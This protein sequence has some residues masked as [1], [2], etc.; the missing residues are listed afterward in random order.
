MNSKKT[1]LFGGTFNPPH[2]GHLLIARNIKKEFNL[3]KIIFIPA[4]IPP[5]KQS[6]NNI[7]DGIHRFEMLKLLLKKEPDFIVSDFELKRKE[8]SYTIETVKYFKN[9][10]LNQEL[11]FIV[12]SD[13]FYYIETWKDYKN[14]LNMINFIIYIRSGYTKEKIIQK[15]KNI[16][17]EKILWSKS[18]QID[19]SSSEIR[20]KISMGENCKEDVGEAVW[21]YIQKNNFY[22]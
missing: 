15:H 6:N 8:I 1:G 17:N 2:I 18:Q 20:A 5:H 14:L 3:D 22:K 13:N 19:I 10:F 21:E 4:N 12:G 11:F 7:I 9:E 16:L